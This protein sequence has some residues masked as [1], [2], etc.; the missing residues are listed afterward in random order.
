MACAAIRFAWTLGIF[1]ITYMVLWW[2]LGLP[3][4]IQGA[5]DSG[6]IYLRNS[7]PDYARLIE[8]FRKIGIA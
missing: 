8:P 3:L 6:L 2:S 5:L 4:G 7:D 1:W